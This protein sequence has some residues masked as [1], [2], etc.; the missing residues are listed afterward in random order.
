MADRWSKPA[1]GASRGPSRAGYS[2]GISSAPRPVR[3]APRTTISERGPRRSHL[4]VRTEV[5]VRGTWT[6]IPRDIDDLGLSCERQ[7]QSCARPTQP[8]RCAPRPCGRCTSRAP[9]PGGGRRSRRSP[10]ES[11]RLGSRRTE[12][13]GRVSVVVLVDLHRGA[14]TLHRVDLMAS[15]ATRFG[16]RRSA[17]SSE[18]L[19]NSSSAK[20]A[21]A[22]DLPVIARSAR[23]SSL[24]WTTSPLRQTQYRIGRQ[25]RKGVVRVS[26]ED[27]LRLFAVS[28]VDQ[29]LDHPNGRDG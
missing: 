28:D 4:S 26:R 23:T 9:R 11:R 5:R 3:N 8:A 20:M 7:L 18:F 15:S 22:C 29:G 24:P 12:A 21:R 19:A 25:R 2:S 10:A 6:P 14:V 13:D 16:C 17:T 27:D 1:A